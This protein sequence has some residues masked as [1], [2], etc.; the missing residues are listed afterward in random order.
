MVG[1]HPADRSN[2]L[3]GACKISKLRSNASILATDSRGCELI[4]DA[5]GDSV[6]VK[7]EQLLRGRFTAAAQ[8]A[9]KPDPPVCPAQ[10]AEAI[11]QAQAPVLVS[12]PAR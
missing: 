11:A 6:L 1:G 7:S 12:D 9:F 5:P 3:P 8:P 4:G 2:R 10:E